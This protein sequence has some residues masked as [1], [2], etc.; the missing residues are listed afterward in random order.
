MQRPIMQRS[1]KKIANKQDLK[2]QIEKATTIED[3]KKIL[4]EIA[5][6]RM[7]K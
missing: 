3:I 7:A 4:L 6:P 2:A 5:Q 1:E